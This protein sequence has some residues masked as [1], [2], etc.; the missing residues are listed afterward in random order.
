MWFIYPDIQVTTPRAAARK[1]AANAPTAAR[2]T[3]SKEQSSVVR[4]V[5]SA[6]QSVFF[7]GSAGTGKSAILSRIIE[8]LPAGATFVTAATG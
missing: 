7:T 3:L 5:V 2:I 8:L 1:E 6:K 4:A